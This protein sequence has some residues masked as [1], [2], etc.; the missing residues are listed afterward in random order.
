MFNIE[1]AHFIVDEMIM[2]GR[3]TET[4]KSNVLR[5]LRT[6]DKVVSAKN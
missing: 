4:N 2:N 3:I 5:P 6:L 1:R